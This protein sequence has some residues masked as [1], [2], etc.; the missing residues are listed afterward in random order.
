MGSEGFSTVVG[1]E[2]LREQFFATLWGNMP[3]EMISRPGELETVMRLAEVVGV[4]YRYL[5][6]V[7]DGNV[8][9][10]ADLQYLEGCLRV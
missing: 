1:Y 5:E 6:W 8:M 7:V 9:S 10:Q 3:P 4:L 2:R